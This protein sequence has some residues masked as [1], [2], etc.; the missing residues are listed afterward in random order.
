M[1]PCVVG[2]WLGNG[3]EVGAGALGSGV[4]PGDGSDEGV[5][6]GDVSPGESDDGD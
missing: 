1:F 2:L 4:G 6:E 5:E 3:S